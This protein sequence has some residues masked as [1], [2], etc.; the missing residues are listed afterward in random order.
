MLNVQPHCEPRYAAA[1][2][3]DETTPYACP[4][5]RPATSTATAVGGAAQPGK[6]KLLSVS[7]S[8]RMPGDAVPAHMAFGAAKVPRLGNNSSGGSQH[9]AGR[10]L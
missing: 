9:S 6:R 8:F 3:A 4:L 5:Y 7:S 1:S 2:K 10:H